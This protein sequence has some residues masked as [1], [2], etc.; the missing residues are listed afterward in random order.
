M[1]R[2][3]RDLLARWTTLALVSAA[4]TALVG[5]AVRGDIG[6]ALDVLALLLLGTLPALRVA[7]LAVRWGRSGD[8]RYSVAAAGLLFLMTIGVVAVATWR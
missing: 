3:E 4:S 6:L 7:V 5:V 1:S 2:V 8:R